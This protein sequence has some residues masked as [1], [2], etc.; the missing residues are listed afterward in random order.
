MRAQVEGFLNEIANSTFKLVIFN[1]FINFIDQLIL[2]ICTCANKFSISDAA[3]GNRI[4]HR[5]RYLILRTNHVLEIYLR[6]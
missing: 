3:Q 4:V 2:S 6:I 5:T 1:L